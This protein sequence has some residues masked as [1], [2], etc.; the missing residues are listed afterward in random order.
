M[1]PRKTKLSIALMQVLGAGLAAGAVALPAMAQQPAAKERIEVTGSNIKRVEGEGAL[2]VTVITREEIDRSGATTAMELLNLVSANSSLGNVSIANTIG[3]LTFSGQTASLRG[4]QGGRT[5]VL[6]N[7]KRVN[8]FA[9]EIQGVQGV[10][11][12]VIPFSAIDR[13]EI[14]KDGAS[15]VYGSDAIAGVI[16]FILRSDYRG[17]EASAYYGAPTRSGGGDVEKYAASAGFGDLSRDRYNFFIS[18]SFDKNHNLEQVDR[19]FSNTSVRLD[20]GLL[21]VSSNTFPGNITTGGIQVPG[22]PNCAPSVFVPE[23]GGCFYDP[24]ADRGVQ[25]IPD[26]KTTNFFASGKFQLTNNWQIYGTGLYSK[27]ENNFQIQPVPISNLFFYGPNGD[28]PSTVEIRPTSPFYP[29]ALATAA[30]VNGQVLNVRYRAYENGHRNTT[31]TNEGWQIVAGTKGSFGR[32]DVDASYTYAEGKTKQVLNGG[33]PLYSLLLPLLNS[34]RVNLFGTNTA[35]IQQELAATNFIGEVF[36]GKSSNEGLQGKISGE[37]MNLPNGPLAMAVGAEGRKEKLTQTP[38]PV[39]ASGDLSG[40]GGNVLPISADRDVTAIYGELNIPIF[41]TLEANVAIRSDDYSDFG[42]TTNPKVSLRWQPSREI[43][44]RASY[45]Q[46]FLAPSLY[47]LFT[48][49]INGVSAPGTSDPI[50]CP[51]TNDTGLDCNTQFPL[52]FGGNPNLNPEESEQATFGVVWEPTNQW[53]FSA[54]YFKIRLNNAITNGIPVATILGD[55]GQYGNLVTRGPST[56]ANPNLPGRI[57]GIQQTY[58]NLGSVHIEGIDLEAHFK[59]PRGKYGRFRLDM[60]GTYYIRNDSQNTDGS[61]TGFVSNQFGGVT[62]GVLP[63]FKSYTAVGWDS[64]P[65]TATLAN[66]YQSGYVDV[67]TDG[68]GDLRRVSTLSLWDLQGTYTGLKGFTFTLGVKNV[69]DTNPPQTN[70]QNS[71]QVGFDP[72]YYDPR[73]RFVYGQVKYEFK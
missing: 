56:P 23:L 18:G 33:F 19:N 72:S 60:S 34:G 69:L 9:G 31:D 55:L 67:S 24:S 68:N 53:S 35:A 63:R 13:V 65:W 46:G 62:T 42:R 16:N 21:G 45:G 30:G 57:T 43:L 12:A 58:I 64:G 5:L 28:I 49:Q 3:S 41:K 70:Q 1:N 17:A 32:W 37:I 59:A 25:M 36:S 22:S 61:Y 48:P 20:L 71:F 6:I 2:P 10:N 8:G 44:L 54:D 52:V 40:F 73:A 15:A 51:I 26:Q 47:Q 39:L 66:T 38:A 29:T 14:L 7:G 11:L 50:R 4:L 27:D